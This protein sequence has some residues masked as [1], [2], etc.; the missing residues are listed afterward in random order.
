M[1]FDLDTKEG[2]ENA[3]QWQTQLC[4]WINE[5]G[6]WLVPRSDQVYLIYKSEKLAVA[7]LGGEPAVNRVFEAMGWEVR[8]EL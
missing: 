2:M 7:P 4:Q 5:G 8:E 6:T 3:V 1:N